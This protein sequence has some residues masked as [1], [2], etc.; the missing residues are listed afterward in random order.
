MAG[1]ARPA[2]TRAAPLLSPKK[3]LE[4][5]SMTN[6]SGWKEAG[7]R[8]DENAGFLTFPLQVCLRLRP[9]LW[10]VA[11]EGDRRGRARSLRGP[12]GPEAPSRLCSCQTRDRKDFPG[13]EESLRRLS[14]EAAVTKCPRPGRGRG[15]RGRN[16]WSRFGAPVHT[17]VWGLRRLQAVR[18][19]LP[20]L[21]P[22]RVGAAVGL[23]LGE[24]LR[25]FRLPAGTWPSPLRL[26]RQQPP[27][28]RGT[29]S[30]LMTSAPTPSPHKGAL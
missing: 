9:R 25:G 15:R 7:F 6:L 21:L 3:L 10:R 20:V 14:P 13:E 5:S 2:R 11:G 8:F 26:S 16:V 28:L 30:G 19:G 27:S 4:G 12:D 24:Q 29:A 22:R 23:P 1:T 18:S 17:G